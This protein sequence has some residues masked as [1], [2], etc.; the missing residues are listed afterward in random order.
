MT[1]PALFAAGPL[2][3]A[4]IEVI[5]PAKTPRTII[6]LRFNP[7]EYQMQKGNAFQE[8]PIPGLESPPIQYIRG[9]SEKLSVEC[10]ADT[11]DS[12]EDVREKFVQPVRAL[13][14]I[15]EELHAPPIVAFTWDREV[16]RGVL[17]SVQVTYT[18]FSPEGVPLRAKMGLTFKEYRS[19]EVQV[20]E[21]PKASPD[22]DKAYLVHAGDTLERIA[23]AVYKDPGNWRVI[24]RRNGI[25]D[26]RRLVPGTTLTIPKIR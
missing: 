8:I 3:P 13:L 2:K 1:T 15:E 10:L 7:T 26:P 5:V 6:P 20:K 23:G 18:L 25:D 19:V 9:N 16:F 12:L 22:F 21:R 17:E 14:N 4:A 24:A 11:S